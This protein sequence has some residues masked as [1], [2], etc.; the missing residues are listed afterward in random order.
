MLIVTINQAVVNLSAYRKVSNSG[1]GYYSFFLNFCLKVTG[2]TVQK[3]AP[4]I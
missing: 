4:T 3:T 2:Q 1:R